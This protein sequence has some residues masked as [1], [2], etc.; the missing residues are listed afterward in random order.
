MPHQ[1]ADLHFAAFDKCEMHAIQVA[2][3]HPGRIDHNDMDHA[4]YCGIS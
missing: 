2:H 3:L 1:L 4:R